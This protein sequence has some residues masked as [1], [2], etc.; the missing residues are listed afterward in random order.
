MYR[1]ETW[2]LSKKECQI[3]GEN[4]WKI[5]TEISLSPWK[6]GHRIF[7]VHCLPSTI[8]TSLRA[9]VHLVPSKTNTPPSLHETSRF[10]FGSSCSG[11]CV[12]QIRHSSPHFVFIMQEV[13]FL[14]W[15]LL[16]FF[17]L[18]QHVTKEYDSSL[19]TIE[20]ATILLVVHFSGWS[21]LTHMSKE[22][23]IAPSCKPWAKQKVTQVT[24]W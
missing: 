14:G 1:K 15:E 10:Y 22:C 5:L 9:T 23:G 20:L 12:F 4:C 8:W 11:S 19:P 7:R 3:K 24:T 16:F 6:D 17:Y 18:W 2:L 21:S 13:G